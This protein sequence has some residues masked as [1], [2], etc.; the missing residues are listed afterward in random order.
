MEDFFQRVYFD[1]TVQ[2]L[3]TT[4]AIILAV[5]LLNRLISQ[6][7]AGLI[8]SLVRRIWPHLDRKAFVDLVIHPLGML[9]VFFVSIGALFKLNLPRLWNVDVYRYNVKDIL[10]ASATIILIVTFIWFL[11]RLI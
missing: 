10:H 11:I 7:L 4:L 8:F 3:L 6:Y 5:I 2:E 9:L 1:N